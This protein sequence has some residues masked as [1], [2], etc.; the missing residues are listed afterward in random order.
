MDILHLLGSKHDIVDLPKYESRFKQVCCWQKIAFVKTCY[1]QQKDTVFHFEIPLLKH[2]SIFNYCSAVWCKK[3]KSHNYNSFFVRLLRVVC[4]VEQKGD[5][6]NYHQVKISTSIIFLTLARPNLCEKIKLLV[7][8]F[9]V[10]QKKKIKKSYHRNGAILNSCISSS[11][12][13]KMLKNLPRFPLQP[14]K[15]LSVNCA[16]KFLFQTKLWYTGSLTWRHIFFFFFSLN[17]KDMSPW[18]CNAVK[19]ERH[20]QLSQKP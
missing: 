9:I 13:C 20:R 1:K 16:V 19:M 4:P 6:R 12:C 17:L 2:S 14:P 5:I 3:K 8:L 7:H 11:Q 18:S 10:S 15:F